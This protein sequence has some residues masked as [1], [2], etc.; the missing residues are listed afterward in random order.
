MPP[1]DLATLLRATHFAADRHR[2]QHR[3]DGTTPYINH[4]LRVAAVLAEC[5]VADATT[6]VAAVLHDTVEDT[7]TSPDEIADLFGPAVRDLVLEVTDDKRLPKAERKRLQVETMR[8]R[9]EAAR[10]IRIADKT[11]NLED[12]IAAPPIDWP[13]E[14]RRAMLDWTSQV[15]DGCRGCNPDLEARY[16]EALR[17]GRALLG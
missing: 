2:S 16:D 5:G 12:L 8:S 15:V 14:R 9:S 11:A 6:L 10:L 13:D 3:K 1:P 7:D 4:P 17:A